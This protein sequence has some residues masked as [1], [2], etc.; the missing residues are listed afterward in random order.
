[1]SFLIGTG[2]YATD[3]EHFL[4]VREFQR[5]LRNTTQATPAPVVVV[6]NSAA[7]IG[8]HSP[9]RVIRIEKNLGHMSAPARHAGR[10]TGWSVSWILPALVAYSEGLD[11][12]YKEQ[13]CFAFGDWVEAIQCG[14][15]TVGRNAIMPCEQSLFFIRQH[16]IPE[17]I[18]RYASLNTSDQFMSTEEKFSKCGAT[19]HPL[20][21]GRDRPITPDATAWYAQ[22]LTESEW[23][24]LANTGLV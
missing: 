24:E 18:G 10:F 2:F 4:K 12:I 6:D 8:A 17:V 16:A 3:A 15:F 23:N 14:D 11:F 22:K 13:D 21:C 1:M 20:G 9:H 7:G 5:W 19:F